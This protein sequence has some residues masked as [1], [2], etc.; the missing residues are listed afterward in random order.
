MVSDHLGSL[1]VP[2]IDTDVIARQVVQPGQPA[3]S[4][5]VE[6]F[7]NEILLEDGSL[8]RNELRQRAFKSDQTKAKL[9]A[10]T[11]P[12]IRIATLQEIQLVEFSYCVVVVPLLTSTS[13]FGKIMNR[14]LVVTADHETK[15]RRVQSRS[16]LSHEEI[17]R[18]MASQL[19]DTERLA[20]ADDVIENNSTLAA[21]RQ[22]TERLHHQYLTLSQQNDTKRL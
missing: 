16:G 19:S 9:D 21:A 7:G 22:A 3:L 2:I 8:N 13:E 5:L 4:A 6:F 1:G 17:E 20:F 18:I 11:H 14:V 15:I 12:A 10:I